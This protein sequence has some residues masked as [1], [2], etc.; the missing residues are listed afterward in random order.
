MKILLVDDDPVSLRIL[1][2]IVAAEPGHEITETTGGEQAWKLLNNPSLFFDVVFLDVSMPETD[3]L[4]VLS[5]IRES[6]ILRSL[7]IVMCTGTSDRETVDKVI[8]HGIRHFIVKPATAPLVHAKLRQIQAEV[9]ADAAPK[10]KR[11]VSD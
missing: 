1:K 3:G 6:Q 5:R 8:K 4:Q 10:P 7:R 2:E 11:R 9:A